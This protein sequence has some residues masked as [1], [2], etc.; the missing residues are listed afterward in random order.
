M[1]LTATCTKCKKQSV[2]RNTMSEREVE[3]DNRAVVLTVLNCPNCK[4]EMTVQVD[5]S[6]TISL[7]Q[8]LLKYSYKVGRSKYF[9][10]PAEKWVKRQNLVSTEL[11]HKRKLLGKSLEGSVYQFNGETKKLEICEP[12]TEF[13]GE[14]EVYAN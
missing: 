1:E 13:V 3:I 4:H 2:V 5:N 6:E 7:Y 10:T 12:T 8:E 14:G 11:M 9:G